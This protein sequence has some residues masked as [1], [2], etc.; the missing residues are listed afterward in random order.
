MM[1]MLKQNIGVYTKSETGKEIPTQADKH[2]V[3]C[4]GS[5]SLGEGVL[6]VK[7][8]FLWSSGDQKTVCIRLPFPRGPE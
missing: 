4:V 5:L 7:D 2:S 8:P 6:Q 1:H 3:I